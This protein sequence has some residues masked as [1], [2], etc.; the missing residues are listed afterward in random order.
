MKIQRRSEAIWIESRKRWQINVQREGVRKTFISSEQGRK[1]K[2]ECEARA[3]KWLATLNTD[4]RFLDAMELYLEDKQKRIQ[5]TSYKSIKASIAKWILPN[6]PPAKKL[7]AISQHD[8]QSIIDKASEA[9]QRESSLKLYAG[10]IFNFIQFCADHNWEIAQIKPLDTTSHTEKKTKTALNA[11]QLGKL[12]ALNPD[13]YHF[14]TLFKLCVLTGIRK[15]E[16]LG[17]QWSDIGNDTLQIRRNIAADGSIH[18]GKTKNALR[19]VPLQSTAVELLQAHKER[20]TKHGIVSLYIFPNERT[21]DIMPHTSLDQCWY[22]VADAIGTDISIHELR[23]TFI[24][25]VSGD[26]PT[27]LLKQAV[28]HSANMDTYGI[29]AHQTDKSLSQSRDII[30]TAFDAMKK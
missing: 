17:L 21:G 25:I 11:D 30:N 27:A 14:A 20:L 7:S 13:E 24:S 1:G 16:A 8:W 12:L 15:G 29:Y 3:D 22:R 10:L 23:H 28:G 9:G 19:S 18:N 2:H 4:Q 5:G 26:M 6:I